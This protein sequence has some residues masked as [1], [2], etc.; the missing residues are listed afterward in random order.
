MSN[1][2]SCSTSSS[3]TLCRITGFGFGFG[4]GTGAGAGACCDSLRVRSC[5]RV[6]KYD[7]IRDISVVT[8]EDS[9]FVCSL[10]NRLV[11]LYV[12]T[13][14]VMGEAG[15]RDLTRC[16]YTAYLTRERTSLFVVQTSLR[17]TEYVVFRDLRSGTAT[18][19]TQLSSCGIRSLF[20]T[21]RVKR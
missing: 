5:R 10:S 3:S 18:I 21:K 12:C 13:G 1:P 11:S 14:N 15:K 20:R 8:G 4:F 9:I 16:A 17:W 2:T 19:R 6:R 7:V